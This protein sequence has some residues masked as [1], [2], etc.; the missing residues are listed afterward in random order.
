MTLTVLQPTCVKLP[1]QTLVTNKISKTLLSNEHGIIFYDF[2][3]A[4]DI[5]LENHA[6]NGLHWPGDKNAL[7][8]FDNIND[9]Y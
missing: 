7:I 4:S 2:V 6:R 1:Y 3:E 9:T 8:F 5:L